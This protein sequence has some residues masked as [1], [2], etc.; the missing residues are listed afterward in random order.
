MLVDTPG[1]VPG[2]RQESAGVIRFGAQTRSRLIWA[3]RSL[4]MERGG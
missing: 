3:L 2:S 1:Y 4:A